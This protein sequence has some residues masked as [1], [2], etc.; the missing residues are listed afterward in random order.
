MS[1]RLMPPLPAGTPG[2]RLAPARLRFWDHYRVAV[3]RCRPP[4]DPSVAV[5]GGQLGSGER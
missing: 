3:M 1:L 2:D 5:P 4:S